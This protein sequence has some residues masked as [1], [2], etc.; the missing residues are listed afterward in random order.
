M[1]EVLRPASEGDA[2]AMVRDA[3]ARKRRIDIVG[4][5]TR[6]GLGRPRRGAADISTAA[7]SGIVFYEPAEMVICAQAGTPVGAI[8]AALDKAGQVLP[9][10]PMDHRALYGSQGEPTIGG[11]VAG[12]VSGP[13]RISA[14]AARDS[15]IGVRL[16]N[17]AGE[18][19]KNGGRVMK[20]V[21]GLDLVKLSCGAHGTLG[22]LTEATLKLLPKPE[23][24]ATIVIRR[25]GDKSAIDAMTR[26]LGSPYF[27]SGAAHLSAG[28]GR[29]FPRTFLRVEGLSESVEYRTGKLLELL[30][31]AGA[32]H[33]LEGPDS[34]RLWRAVRDAEYLAEPRDNAVWRISTA[35]SHGADF[36]A[37]LGPI[38]L[39]Y[40]YDWG[41]G[42][43]WAST[44][45]TPEACIALRSTLAPFGGHATLMR[46]PDSLRAAMDVFA[47]LSAP[48]MRITR[49]LKESFDPDGVL[50]SG[51]MYANL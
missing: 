13:R 15:L 41:G 26:A 28:M 9:F 49:G 29:E 18:I 2:A 17:G 23:R 37:R 11:I 39:N 16:V 45:P 25:L 36:V 4:G 50:N 40:F 27:V 8:E 24:Q 14:G 3:R 10:E 6:S 47:P 31:Q 42:L 44:A 20:N 30:G 43:V 34:A 48:L 32:R 21:T 35:P 38:A 7:L 19:V 1:S 33:A 5:G 51:R 22:L 46:A 12:N